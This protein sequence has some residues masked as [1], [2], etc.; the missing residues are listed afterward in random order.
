[1]TATLYQFMKYRYPEDKNRYIVTSYLFGAK[2]S[3]MATSR[4]RL[5]LVLA[6]GAALRAVVYTWYPL[7][8]MLGSRPEFV[9]ATSSFR[10]LKESVFL[11]EH[12]K[13]PYDGDVFHQPPLVFAAFYPLFLLPE[14]YQYVA[15][16]VLFILVDLA[17]ALGFVRL[18]K[19]TLALEQ[20]DAPTHGNE[21]IW[22]NQIALSP[23]FEP[24]T[25][26]FTVAAL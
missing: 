2:Q 10:R 4:T 16:S 23:I 3:K 7:Q 6:A 14:E 11:F 8:T 12:G 9:T 21:E 26:P 15:A 5:A 18:C 17:I 1:M 13:S 20:R 24:D 22:L 19:R 25:L